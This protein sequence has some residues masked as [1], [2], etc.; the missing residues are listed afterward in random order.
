[1]NSMTQPNI[2]L[3]QFIN[4]FPE[5]E[6]PITLNEE[7][8]HVFSQKNGPVP[9]AIVDQYFS[10][11][12]DRDE[13]GMTEYVACFR[14]PET[15]EFYGLVYWKAGL[16]NYEYTLLT[17]SKKGDMIDKKVIAGTNSDGNQLI[18]SVATIDEDWIIYIVSGQS[19]SASDNYDPTSS[20]AFKL[21]LLPEGKIIQLEDD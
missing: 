1:M 17:I 9:K 10:Y 2:S 14:I 3:D 11:L 5:I 21:E 19:Q 13:L 15:H 12:E 6:L 8:H 20:T 7:V 18:H 16:L 4:L